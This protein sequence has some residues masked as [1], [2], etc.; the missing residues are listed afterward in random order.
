MHKVNIV[1]FSKEWT[2]VRSLLGL[3]SIS[4]FEEEQDI[5]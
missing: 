5:R 2:K 3:L 4:L 1:L